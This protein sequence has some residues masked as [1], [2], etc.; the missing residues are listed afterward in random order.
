MAPPSPASWGRGPRGDLRC[1]NTVGPHPGR[2]R[3]S[4]AR[5]FVLPV[6]FF[7]GARRLSDGPRRMLA[8]ANRRPR[9]SRRRASHGLVRVRARGAWELRCWRQNRGRSAKNRR[10]REFGARSPL[11]GNA[12]QRTA[13][14]QNGS[15]Q[16]PPVLAGAGARTTLDASFGPG[17]GCSIPRR[18]L[19]AKAGV[20]RRSAEINQMK[21]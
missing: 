7:L 9:P 16:S 5:A 10:P 14:A 2:G 8:H 21:G 4:T 17:S 19:P 15:R 1:V 12:Q 3:A 20:Q 18:C 13:E 11:E 6:S